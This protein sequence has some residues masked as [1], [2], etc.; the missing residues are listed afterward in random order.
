MKLFILI[1]LESYRYHLGL[2]EKDSS[3]FKIM[4]PE[5]QERIRSF[6]WTEDMGIDFNVWIESFNTAPQRSSFMRWLE[7]AYTKNFQPFRP[8]MKGLSCLL[9]AMEESALAILESKT[10]TE[11]GRKD[12]NTGRHLPDL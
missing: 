12:V 11:F 3:E 2:P 6:Y 1:I 7:E 10:I 5:S 4:T 8:T 9:D